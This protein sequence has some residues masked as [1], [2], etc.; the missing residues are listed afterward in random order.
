MLSK[1]SVTRTHWTARQQSVAEQGEESWAEK[2]GVDWLWILCLIPKS[3]IL[4]LRL[5]KNNHFA[6]FISQTVLLP[7]SPEYLKGPRWILTTLAVSPRS[8]HKMCCTVLDLDKILHAETAWLDVKVGLRW[9]YVSRIPREVIVLPNY[10]DIVPCLSKLWCF[11][12]DY[13]T[14]LHFFC[15]YLAEFCRTIDCLEL[16]GWMAS[17]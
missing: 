14:A 10:T 17:S 3:C 6:L 9:L 11:K 12:M 15:S 4:K 7:S 8:G 1:V 2:S 16:L 13:K 5:V